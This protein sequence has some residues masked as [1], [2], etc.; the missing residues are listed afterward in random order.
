[1]RHQTVGRSMG[2]LLSDFGH[3]LPTTPATPATARDP[4]LFRHAS[5]RGT[6]RPGRG[7][8]PATAPVSAWRM[9]SDQAPVLWPFISTPGLAPT[10]AQIGVD[11]L[12]GVNEHV[13]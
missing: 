7:W 5:I 6:H 2:R 12:S 4:R 1:M 8:S 13:I 9:T 3:D 11:H 10:G